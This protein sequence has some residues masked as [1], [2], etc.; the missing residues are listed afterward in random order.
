M[1]DE[2]ASMEGLSPANAVLLGKAGV[3][4]LDD[5]ADLAGDELQ[6]IIGEDELSIEEANGVIM[7]ARA[8]WFD[9]DSD[10]K[11]VEQLN[12]D[13]SGDQ[14]SGGNPE[15]DTSENSEPVLVSTNDGDDANVLEP[16]A[17]EGDGAVD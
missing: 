3:K 8:H 2:V 16:E 7:A 1:S 12:V 17:N 11:G 13:Q 14:A 5:L 10:E 9:D 4:S 6:E 15:G